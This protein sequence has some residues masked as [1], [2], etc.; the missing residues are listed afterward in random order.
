MQT[1]MKVSA[2]LGAVMFVFVAEAG[3][4]QQ[5]QVSPESPEMQDYIPPQNLDPNLMA[6][7]IKRLEDRL[8]AQ[9]TTS[10]RLAERVVVL[11]ENYNALIEFLNDPNNARR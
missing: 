8:L 11:T 1:R 4:A 2:I 6:I 3:F 5:T 9:E 10:E 7:Q